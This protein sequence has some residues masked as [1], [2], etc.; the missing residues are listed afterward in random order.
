MEVAGRRAGLPDDVVA[1]AL[2]PVR[3][4]AARDVVGGPA[5]VEVRRMAAAM[6]AARLADAAR[7]DGFRARLAG[8]AVEREAGLRDLAG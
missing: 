5:P 6:E 7:I 1:R 3:G 4:V 2:D 8:A